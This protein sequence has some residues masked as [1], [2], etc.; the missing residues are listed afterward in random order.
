[1]DAT[2]F[3]RELA[4]PVRQA[5]ALLESALAHGPG[6]DPASSTRAFRFYMSDV[7]QVEFLP[8][9]VE[10]TQRTAPGVRLEAV[11]A[12]CRGHRGRARGR[13]AGPG[14]RLPAGPG[15]AGAAPGAVPRS[16]RLPDARRPSGGRRH[17]DQEE[18]RRGVARAGVLPRRPPRHRGGARA[19]R[20]RAAHRA[21]RAALHRGAD[22][23]GAQRPAPHAAGA[24]RARLRA[25]R[26][27]QVAAAAGADPAR[28]SRPC[29][30]TS[31]SRRTR[32][33]AGCAR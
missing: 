18:V 32:A 3:A 29:T 14:G 22:G 2:P 25:A 33:T 9:L 1:M 27:S 6:F 7:G 23:A 12:R 21:A 28:R 13:S 11:G 31:A 24:R 19:R 26:Q 5:L 4:E 10:R 17:A 16:L 15:R 20:R 8:P 30:G